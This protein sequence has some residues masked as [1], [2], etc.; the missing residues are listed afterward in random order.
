MQSHLVA[1]SFMLNSASKSSPCDVPDISMSVLPNQVLLES[2]FNV[3]ELMHV[4]SCFWNL[5]DVS[6]GY[7]QSIG[8]ISKH[9]FIVCVCVCVCV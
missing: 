9:I 8:S 7:N 2:L 3:W 5:D 6:D 1:H 4:Y